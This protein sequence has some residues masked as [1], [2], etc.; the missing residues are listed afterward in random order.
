[1][2]LCLCDIFASAAALRKQEDE[3]KYKEGWPG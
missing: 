1:M 3:K 2:L